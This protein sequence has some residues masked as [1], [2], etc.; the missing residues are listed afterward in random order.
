[1]KNHQLNSEQITAL[2]SAASVGTLATLNADGTPYA[3]PIHFVFDGQALY[4]HGLLVGQKLGNL[5]ANP[6]VSFTAWNMD[7]L[8]YDE[9]GHPCETNTKYQSVIIQGRAEILTDLAEKRAILDLII[10]KYTPHQAGNPFSDNRVK[11]TAVVKIAIDQ[12]TGKYY[13]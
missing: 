2:L 9:S 12:I 11:G 6:A 10:R 1:M 5:K 13:E 7:G 3:T 8:L 4:F